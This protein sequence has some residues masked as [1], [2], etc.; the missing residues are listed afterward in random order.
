MKTVRLK[1]KWPFLTLALVC[2]LGTFILGAKQVKSLTAFDKSEYQALLNQ[3]IL[4]PTPDNIA[5][6]VSAQKSLLERAAAIAKA[7]GEINS[8]TAV[9]VIAADDRATGRTQAELLQSMKEAALSGICSGLDSTLFASPV[10]DRLAR[11][12]T[13]GER[14]SLQACIWY[15]EQLKAA[16]T[17]HEKMTYAEWQQRNTILLSD[18]VS[19]ITLMTVFQKKRF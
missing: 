15:H 17:G 1:T 7:E 3:A 14:K 10:G 8:L 5:S 2:C 16:A 19:D 4:Y 18:S 13:D 9:P 11:P 6:Y 12:L